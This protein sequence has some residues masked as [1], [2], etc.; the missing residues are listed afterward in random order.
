MWIV[1]V[2]FFLSGFGVAFMF[3]FV[4]KRHFNCKDARDFVAFLNSL[5]KYVWMQCSSLQF[6]GILLPIPVLHTSFGYCNLHSDEDHF[7]RIYQWSVK[8]LVARGET[9]IF[10]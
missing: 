2:F 1:L 4:F 6:S 3:C 10:F 5:T 7:D 8:V 9:G